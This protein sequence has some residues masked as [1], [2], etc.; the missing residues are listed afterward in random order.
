MLVVQRVAVRDDGVEAVV[1]AEP[2]EDDEDL[3]GRVRGDAAA[4]LGQYGWHRPDAAEEAEAQ[5]AGA[6]PQ[7]VATR[8]AAVA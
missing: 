2:F 4:R 8:D 6:E 7:H 5:A 1:A 3:A